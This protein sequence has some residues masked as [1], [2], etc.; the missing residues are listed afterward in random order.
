MVISLHLIDLHMLIGAILC[1]LNVYRL[2]YT[3]TSFGKRVIIT[4]TACDNFICLSTGLQLR[5]Q[6]GKKD[7]Q[8][9][10]EFFSI[11]K[12]LHHMPGFPTRPYRL[13]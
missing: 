5:R 1:F 7:T 8:V 9:V 11:F 12:T 6:R 2:P 10:D 4:S 3:W 13:D